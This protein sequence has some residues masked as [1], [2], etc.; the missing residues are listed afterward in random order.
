MEEYI[1]HVRGRTIIHC[2]FCAMIMA[3]YGPD[4][5]KWVKRVVTY[6]IEKE[7]LNNDL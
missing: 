7:R 1:T 4:L 6:E 3:N 2:S 5:M